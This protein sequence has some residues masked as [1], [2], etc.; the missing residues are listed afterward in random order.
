MVELIKPILIKTEEKDLFRLSRMA[1][2]EAKKSLKTRQ[3]GKP[4]WVRHTPYGYVVLVAFQR[5]RLKHEER[6]DVRKGKCE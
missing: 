4:I 3:H 1:C 2:A 6:A 5:E